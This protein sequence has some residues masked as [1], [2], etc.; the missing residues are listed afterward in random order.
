MKYLAVLG[1]QPL[2]SVAEL[3]ALYDEVTLTGGGL[4]TFVTETEVNIARLGG[5]LKLA[6]PI[7]GGVIDYLMGLPKGKITLGV[8]D[9]RTG[10]TK[11]ESSGSGDAQRKERNSMRETEDSGGVRRKGRSRARG[12]GGSAKRA[13]AEAARLKRLLKRAGRSVRV[14]PNKAT[15]L[16]TAAVLHNGLGRKTRAVELLWTDFGWYVGCG[17]QDIEAY[18]R[19][20]Q[21]RPARDAK[22]GMLP[23]K[24]AQ[25]LI[26]LCGELP[27]GARVLDPFC[28]TGVVLQEAM[29]MEYVPYGT[30]LSERMVDYSRKNLSWLMENSKISS[31]NTLK[32]ARP[33]LWSHEDTFEFPPD[34]APEIYVPDAKFASSR[35]DKL[36]LEQ[37]D[38]TSYVWRR[39]IDAVAGEIFLGPAMNKMPSEEKLRAVKQEIISLLYS[40]L[41]NLSSQIR[42][43]T[44]VTLAI[45]AWRRPNGE[46]S[47]LNVLDEIEKLGYNVV[48]YKNVRQRDLLYYREGQNVARE[49]ISLRKK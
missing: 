40:F 39:P 19:R 5:T 7:E 48:K 16:S 34:N 9:Y 31:F 38:A 43:G 6:R 27:E 41:S 3:E 42:P 46:Y 20:D 12:S 10:R 13:Q 24:L 29:L 23:P 49:I 36:L 22:V 11:G 1:R 4:A 33:S 8:S 35:N 17:V 45:P 47:R 32:A 21:A 14:L 26:N 18:A 30:D 44:P 28:G 15:V 37:G 25:I 2:I